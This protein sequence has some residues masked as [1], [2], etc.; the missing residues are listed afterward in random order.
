[1]G[2]DAARQPRTGAIE[3]LARA[4]RIAPEHADSRALVETATAALEH[5]VEDLDERGAVALASMFVLDELAQAHLRHL[6]AAYVAE[7]GP[8]EG[9]HRRW[10]AGGQFLRVLMRA[11]RAALDAGSKHPLQSRER[12]ELMVRQLRCAG[13]L[14]KWQALAYYP[15]DADL[16][17]EVVSIYR[18][19]R[20]ERLETRQVGLRKARGAHTSIERELARLMALEAA[21]LDQLA[22]M[23]IDVADRVLRY[24]LPAFRLSA[25]PVPGS[26]IQLSLDRIAP[27]R[28]VEP[29]LVTAGEAL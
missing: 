28:K 18:A 22:P 5:C 2:W 29:D 9:A 8:V 3:A 1:M 20:D 11:Y 23:S 10:A 14:L 24:A 27:P 25:M 16:W 6:T 17:R 7:R 13:N 15:A 12:L 19:A 26:M 4:M 21:A